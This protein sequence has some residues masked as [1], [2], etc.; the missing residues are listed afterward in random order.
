[1]LHNIFSSVTHGISELLQINN[2][3]IVGSFFTFNSGCLKHRLVLHVKDIKSGD[4]WMFFERVGKLAQRA[5]LVATRRSWQVIESF[6][7]EILLPDNSEKLLKHLICQELIR[8]QT[9]L[10][11]MCL[12]NKNAASFH[13]NMLRKWHN[14]KSDCLLAQ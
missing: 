10:R 5:S 11:F 3:L 8:Y 12:T 7:L 4:H 2:C 13:V 14:P 9:L 6:P 1:M